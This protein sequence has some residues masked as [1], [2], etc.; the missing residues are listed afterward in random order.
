MHRNHPDNLQD[1][2]RFRKNVETL[3]ASLR[4]AHPDADVQTLLAPLHQLAENEDFWNHTLD[5]LAA[6]GCAD[7]FRVF[8][9]PRTLPELVLAADIF[10]TKPLR[11]F[12]QSVERYQCYA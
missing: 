4:L 8:V 9:L 10:H 2:I 12:L 3:G 7:A 11:R 1:P 6:L 5:G